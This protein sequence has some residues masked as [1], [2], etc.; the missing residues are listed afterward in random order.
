MISRH[1]DQAN[2]VKA[3]VGPMPKPL[4]RVRM[5]DILKAK[6]HSSHAYTKPPVVS[7]D[8][9]LFPFFLKQSFLTLTTLTIFA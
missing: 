6:K 1:Y 3:P 4:D 7:F 5:L 8:Q 2:L 9:V